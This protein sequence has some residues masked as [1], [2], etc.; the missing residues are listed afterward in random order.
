MVGD[1]KIIVGAL[2]LDASNIGAV[3]V[4]NLDGN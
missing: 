4:Y 1:S 3:Y 2:V